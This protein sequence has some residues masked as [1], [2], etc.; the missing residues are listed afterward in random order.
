MQIQNS[1]IL[2]NLRQSK[3][4]ELFPNLNQEKTQKFTSVILTFLALSFFGIFA[5]NPTISTIV[6]LRRELA[7]NT[8]TEK[9]LAQ[10]ISNL[11][12]LGKEYQ[13]LAD[14]IPLILNAVPQ[15]PQISLLVAQL[16]SLAK[17][18]GV[19][20][21]GLQTFQVEVATPTTSKKKY[22][23]FAFSLTAEGSYN[24][25]LALVENVVTMQRVVSLDTIALNRK[26]DQSETFQIGLKGTAYFKN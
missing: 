6:R 23:S 19:N 21:E 11:S 5:I 22:S 1:R 12:S 2:K 20:L 4:L 14:D 9:Q 24:S 16:Q 17:N 25:I 18:S 8:F 13:Q 3:Y 7:D 26:A 10:K 15:D